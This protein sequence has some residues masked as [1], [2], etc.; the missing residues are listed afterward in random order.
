MKLLLDECVDAR[1]VE[2]L[3]S[4]G[5]DVAFVQAADPS[6]DDRAVL[7]LALDEARVLVTTDLDF[8]ELLVRT[9]LRN[10]GVVLLRLEGIPPSQAAARVD[11][12]LATHGSELPGHLLVINRRRDRLRR[13]APPPST[14]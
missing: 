2:P 12:A 7:A 6:A 10:H 5:H 9:G 13:L 3:R 8:G 4:F 14:R 11:A 1:V